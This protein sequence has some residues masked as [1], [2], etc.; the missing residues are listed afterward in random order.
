MNIHLHLAMETDLLNKYCLFDN[1]PL[2]HDKLYFLLYLDD[3]FCIFLFTF[4]THN[5]SKRKMKMQMQME[6]LLQFND[7]TEY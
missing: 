6:N 3:A 1:T 7:L 2:Y 4:I 5:N